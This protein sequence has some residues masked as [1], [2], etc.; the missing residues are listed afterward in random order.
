M[1]NVLRHRNLETF[2]MAELQ[3]EHDGQ[4]AGS[5]EEA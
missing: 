5:A 1:S 2:G 4:T 3:E